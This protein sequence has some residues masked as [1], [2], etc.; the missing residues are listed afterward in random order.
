MGTDTLRRRDP[1]AGAEARADEI[2]RRMERLQGAGL[3]G[4][5]TRGAA[6]RRALSADDLVGAYRLVDAIGREQSG[7]GRRP[8]ALR[9]GVHE[10]SPDMATFIAVAGG[11]VVGV[12]GLAVD[13]PEVGLPSDGAFQDVLDDLRIQGRFIC[14]ATNLAVAPAFRRSAVPTELMR[15]LFAHCLYVGCD[16]LVTAVGPG[17]VPF[18]DLLGFEQA[19]PVRDSLDEGRGPGVL[20]RVNVSDLVRW[21][22]Q[23]HDDGDPAALFIKIRCLISNPYRGLVEDWDGQAG[24]IFDDV[25]A[26]RRIFV[27]ES[28]LVRRCTAQEREAIRGFWGP[29]TFA[30]V[31]GEAAT[32][33]PALLSE[34]AV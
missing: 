11:A 29:Q 12:Q 14:E 17:H 16:E 23:A 22:K 13:C 10:A 20:M 25:D 6:I 28:G 1:D 30:R 27:E 18:Y 31:A 3:F 26:L 24:R 32:G 2:T 8:G 21:A 7:A 15:C 9:L 34:K 4:A 33:P 5:D 19:S